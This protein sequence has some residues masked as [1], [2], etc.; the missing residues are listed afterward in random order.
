MKKIE[1]LLLVVAVMALV[2]LIG[3]VDPV[4]H[5]SYYYVFVISVGM[6]FVFITMIG[7]GKHG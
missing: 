1:M 6:I 7:K 5:V 4:M 3:F 2:V